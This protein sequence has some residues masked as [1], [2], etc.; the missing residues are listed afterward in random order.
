[1]DKDQFRRAL[2]MGLGR[3][4]L[5]ARDHD[6]SKFKDIILDA[7]LHCYSYDPQIE[8][9]RA[10]YMLELVN[11]L[12]DKDF[13]HGE[14]LKALT[15]CGDDYDA[16]QRFRIA[17]YL[18][19]DGNK[20][21]KKAMYESYDPGP[22]MGEAIALLFLHMDGIDGL[23]FAA[24]KIGALLLSGAEKVD[25]GWLLSVSIET[26]G[27]KQFWDA[28]RYEGARNPR[29]ET[30]RLAAEKEHERSQ[31]RSQ[32]IDEDMKLSYPQLM[33]NLQ[34]M[35][36]FRIE[37][38]GE[39]AQD[40]EIEL[41]ANGLAVT[42]NARELRD[43]L[44]IFARR[45]FPFD[46]GILI[47]LIGMDEERVG[48]AAVIA[49]ANVSD[50]RVRGIAFRL[51]ETRA[52]QRGLVI[53]LLAQNF[54]PGDHAIVLGWFE[55][56][57]DEEARHSM[58]MDLKSFWERHPNDETEVPMLRALYEQGP[59]SFCREGSVSRLIERNALPEDWRSEC[60]FDANEDIRELVKK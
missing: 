38:W 54:E 45:R 23:L 1:M 29:T 6:V 24:E 49:L 19:D 26:F 37:R 50:P 3:A 58:G 28:L 17:A 60:G 27:E 15:G 43:H 32:T 5:C 42:L 12:P 53:D 21:A 31:Q 13:F 22:A 52:N 33:A 36:Q 35:T 47:N 46:P 25:L 48:H 9:T 55:T 18:A 14:V 30:F 57:D 41:A 8:G 34:N 11:M 39:H 44:R 59:C 20:R 4:F 10:N 56:E 2:H 51:V 40:A 7:C 16:V